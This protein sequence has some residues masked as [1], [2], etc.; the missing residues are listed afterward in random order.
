MNYKFIFIF[1]SVL[2]KTGFLFSQPPTFIFTV[3]EDLSNNSNVIAV[4]FVKYYNGKYELI[5][6][7]Y[8]RAKPKDAAACKNAKREMYSL[9]LSGLLYYLNN[10]HQDGSVRV[11][12]A[13]EYGFSDW[14]TV[15]LII[16]ENP[17]VACLTNNRRIGTNNLRPVTGRPK[18]PAR[19]N[20]EGGGW[21]TDKLL[22]KIDIDMDGM[23]ELIYKCEDYEGYFYV[24]Y[25]YKNGMWEKVFEG[26]YQGV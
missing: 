18:L 9:I 14:Q 19:R 13:T 8:D 16:E 20:H 3:E 4:P 15:S 12:Q 22:T 5:S 6:K 26:G 11:Q 2:I 17:G 21:L 1:F 25:S 10:G 7:C 23:P 24:I